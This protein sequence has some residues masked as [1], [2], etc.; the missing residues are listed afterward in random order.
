L[1]WRE[2]SPIDLRGFQSRL[3]DRLDGISEM[4]CN[5]SIWLSSLVKV[6]H[7]DDYEDGHWRKAV[8][9]STSVGGMESARDEIHWI[10]NKEPY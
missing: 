10:K 7:G 2:T 4:H 5:L 3:L 9:M 8:P 6:D 1:Q